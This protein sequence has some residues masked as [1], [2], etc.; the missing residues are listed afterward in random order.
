[1]SKCLNNSTIFYKP[2]Y[3]VHIYP[4]LSMSYTR[5]LECNGTTASILKFLG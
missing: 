1:M 3:Y 2:T 5:Y 4:H